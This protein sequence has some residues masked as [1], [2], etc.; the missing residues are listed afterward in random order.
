MFIVVTGSQLA[1]VPLSYFGEDVVW[2]EP[3]MLGAALLNCVWFVLALLSCPFKIFPD[4]KRK[5]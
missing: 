2:V 3:R 4:E 5:R 1:P